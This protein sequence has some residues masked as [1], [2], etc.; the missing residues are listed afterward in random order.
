MYIQHFGFNEHPFRLTPD[1]SFLYLSKMHARAKSYMDFTT[2]S[3]D[4]FVVITGEIGSGKTTLI[5]ALLADLDDS[6]LMA[7]VHQTQLNDVEFLQAILVEFGFNPFNAKKVELL[8]MLNMHLIEQYGQGKRALLIVDEAQNLSK[9]VLEEVRLL[10]G[11][12]TQ[13]EKI[14]N[15]MLVGQPEL[16]EKLNAP[17]LE[18][19]VQRIR[20]RFHLKSLGRKDTGNYIRHRIEVAGGDNPGLFTDEAVQLVYKF[21]GGVP[22]LINTLCD[23][24][25]ICAFADNVKTISAHG[26]TKAVREL[27]WVPYAERNRGDDTLGRDPR[28]SSSEH[29]RKVVI[30]LK[31]NAI[32]EYPMYKERIT[33]GRR[34]N[35]DIHVDD[36]IVSRTHAQLI[37]HGG[38]VYIEDLKS[39]NGTYVNSQRISSRSLKNDDLITI[40][41]YHLKYV[42]EPSFPPGFVETR[43]KLDFNGTISTGVDIKVAEGLSKASEESRDAE[44]DEKAEGKSA[45]GGK[46]SSAKKKEKAS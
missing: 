45:S 18:Q 6:V 25:L 41:S 3:R 1:S 43:D 13:K 34:A 24:A 28:L 32:G 27:Q 14:L 20:F 22:R 46:S 21:T 30:T 8:N 39:E 37:T 10:S 19:L 17:E 2:I 44:V 33:I 15:V 4:S 9:R 23:T 40:G 31:G 5:Q 12:E 7:R 29:I 35:N 42:D 16:N 38:E 26:V 11:L 36:K